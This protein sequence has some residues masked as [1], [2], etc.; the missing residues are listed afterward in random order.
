[1]RLPDRLK[2]P[3]LGAHIIAEALAAT[4]ALDQIACLL[5]AGLRRPRLDIAHLRS[6]AN[7]RDR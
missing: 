6:A 1:M 2:R 3:N 5:R 4:S 7:S